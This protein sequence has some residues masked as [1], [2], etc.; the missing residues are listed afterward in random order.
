M[1]KKVRQL[2]NLDIK[3]IISIKE[4]AAVSGGADNPNRNPNNGEG[5]PSNPNANKGSLNYRDET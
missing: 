3:E 4:L 1:K 2:E 5:G